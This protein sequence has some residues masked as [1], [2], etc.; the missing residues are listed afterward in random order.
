MKAFLVEVPEYWLNFG[1]HTLWFSLLAGVVCSLVRDAGRKAFIAAA[2]VFAIIVLPWLT[3]VGW[4][5]RPA[6]VSAPASEVG[7]GWDG[8]TV[9][10]VVDGPSSP[11][12]EANRADEVVASE[13]RF[14]WRKIVPLVWMVP[15]AFGL[16][17]IGFRQVGI[18]IKMKSLRS[19]SD[20]EWEMVRKE[21][22]FPRERFLV[23]EECVSP[24][25]AG[26]FRQRIVV[27]DF[28]FSEKEE[29]KLGWAL[30]HEAEHVRA[31]DPRVA[32]L[33]SVCRAAMWWNPAVWWLSAVW[34]ERREMVCDDRAARVNGRGEYGGFLVEMAERLCFS[35]AALPMASGKPAV[36]LRRRVAVLLGGVRVKKESKI[37][38]MGSVACVLAA[39][40]LVSLSG[41]RK[42][43]A[44]ESEPLVVEAKKVSEPEKV[45][46]RMV[47]PEEDP[48]E[49]GRA[50]FQVKMESM[51]L[52][53]SEAIRE[54]GRVISEEEKR[55]LL[56]RVTQARGSVITTAPSVT[57]KS[58]QEARVEIIWTRPG[59]SGDDYFADNAFVGLV[60]NLRPRIGEGF[61]ESPVVCRWN[62]PPGKMAGLNMPG[63]WEKP[64]DDFDW[65]TLRSA[66]AKAEIKLESGQTVVV[67]FD[68]AEEGRYLT[69][70]FKW[71]WIDATGRAMDR[72]GKLIDSAS[73]LRD[74]GLVK[75]RGAIV[76]PPKSGRLPSYLF[77]ELKAFD[78]YWYPSGDWGRMM[79]EVEKTEGKGAWVELGS[80]LISS[81]KP[82][83]PWEKFQVRIGLEPS[84]AKSFEVS[85]V[86]PGKSTE[87]RANGYIGY[88]MGMPIDPDENG[89]KRWLLLSFEEVE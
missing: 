5:Q 63:G 10:V 62:Y 74:D 17:V 23:T 30:R 72:S 20:H 9:R 47:P 1:L 69:G 88:I 45:R 34:A 6:N 41:V 33:L 12:I 75:V 54:A 31:N 86:A 68:G 26:F 24:C 60:M 57:A 71:T 73:P 46:D 78:D 89:R 67:A 48:R 2:G 66:T 37:F 18:G 22:D 13:S 59:Y 15:V 29:R 58:G 14:D 52:V 64:A 32:L 87:W 3:A 21:S 16:G 76:T 50:P 85:L 83:V 39:G 7:G 77:T 4:M 65:S 11:L 55:L 44:L 56:Q 80:G 19:F 49:K 51:F 81:G 43:A 70:L 61:I 35:S 38:R 8:W 84:V 40:L 36:R 42:A 25:A 79:G 53:T 82:S 28:L 27:P